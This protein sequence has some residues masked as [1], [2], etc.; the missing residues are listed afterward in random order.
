MGTIRHTT[1]P[2]ATITTP[3]RIT[4]SRQAIQTSTSP[5]MASSIWLTGEPITPG[6][7]KSRARVPSDRPEAAP[8]NSASRRRDRSATS[9]AAAQMPVKRPASGLP[10]T[11]RTVATAASHGCRRAM[12]RM[13]S[14]AAASPTR[15][16]IRPPKRL[17]RTVAAKTTLPARGRSESLR[18]WCPAHMLIAAAIAPVIATPPPEDPSSLPRVDM[19]AGA[20][21]E[22][23]GSSRPPYQPGHQVTEPSLL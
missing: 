5:V 23:D 18:I 22:Y 17:S 4:G 3:A 7:W 10:R 20:T 19:M 6:L 13:A 8:T 21:T 2:A 15:N 16:V 9:T 1:S 12:A 11:L 14:D